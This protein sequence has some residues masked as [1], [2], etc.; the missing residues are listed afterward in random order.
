M[1]CLLIACLVALL[2]RVVDQAIEALIQVALM[3]VTGTEINHD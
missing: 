3:D 1:D 2:L